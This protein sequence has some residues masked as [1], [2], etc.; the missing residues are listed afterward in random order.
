MNTFSRKFLIFLMFSTILFINSCSEDLDLSGAESFQVYGTNSKTGQLSILDTVLEKLIFAQS[1]FA[2]TGG[3]PAS[4]K[5]KIYSMH[6][7][8][9]PDC[10]MPVELFDN[11]TIPETKELVGG[12]LLGQ[13]T[14]EDGTYTCIIIKM[15][16]FMVFKPDTIAVNLHPGCTDTD[17]EY[18][19]DIYRDGD[20]NDGTWNDINGESIDATGTP[21]S[22]GEDI[23]YLFASTDP[24]LVSSNIGVNINQTMTLTSTLIA[25]G[26]TTLFVDFTDKVTDY[27]G[28]CW[29]EAPE[30]GFQ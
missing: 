14:P 30:V 23:V 5:V 1:A 7:S 19:F 25:P 2:A 28:L 13:G 3:N 21:S 24:S 8:Q 18:T 20:E 26:D 29:V 27:S 22:P 4:I 12:T 11:G 17:N 16:D 6:I 9:N 10:S 15:S